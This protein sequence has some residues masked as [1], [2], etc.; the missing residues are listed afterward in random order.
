MS[1]FTVWLLAVTCMVAAMV[2]GFAIARA[3]DGLVI[4]YQERVPGPVM[5]ASDTVQLSSNPVQLPVV[6]TEQPVILPEPTILLTPTIWC[7]PI[8]LSM[9]IV[10]GIVAV[11]SFC[12]WSDTGLPEMLGFEIVK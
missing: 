2:M 1:T 10:S 8:T 9:P 5:P 4:T 11:F 7:E 3:D 12:I 6:S